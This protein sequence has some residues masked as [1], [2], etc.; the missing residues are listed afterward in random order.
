MLF[1]TVVLGLLFVLFIDAIA[2]P[3]RGNSIIPYAE[4][5]QAIGV[6]NVQLESPR[7]R[8]AASGSSSPV[9]RPI[10]NA[11]RALSGTGMRN[12][13]SLDALRLA[14]VD[15]SSNP[16]EATKSTPVINDTETPTCY[17][18]REAAPIA[19]PAN[20]NMAIYE[21][22]GRR[23]PRDIKFWRRSKTWSYGTCKVQLVPRNDHGDCM[24]RQTL[25]EAASLIKSHCITA[26]HGYRGGYAA[27]G[28]RMIFDLKVWASTSS[29]IVNETTPEFS[30]LSDLPDLSEQCQIQR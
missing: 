19:T 20:C 7:S 21:M 11:R 25:S 12:G 6:S 13:S 29:G 18:S 17:G 8:H 26:E 5:L 22:M 4:P 15:N 1:S 10:D 3:S 16:V 9:S 30:I 14:L 28:I 27:V 24:T 23:D 2:R